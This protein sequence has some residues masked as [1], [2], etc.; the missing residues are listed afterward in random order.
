MPD[1]NLDFCTSLSN[2][3]I[4]KQFFNNISSALSGELSINPH[5]KHVTIT[6]ELSVKSEI[7]IRNLSDKSWLA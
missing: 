1:A 3:I 2:H 7:K 6:F 5:G 4:F